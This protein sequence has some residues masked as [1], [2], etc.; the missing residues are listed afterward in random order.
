MNTPG[1]IVHEWIARSGGSEKV[2]E[3]FAR[4]FP[5]API[6]CLWNDTAAYPGRATE[7]WLGRS[8]FRRSKALA[9]PLMPATWR[10]LPRRNVDWMLVSSHLFAHHAKFRGLGVQPQKFVYVH[11]PARYIWNPELDVRGQNRAV[12]ALAPFLRNLDRSRAAEGA[13]FAANS[14]FVKRRINNAWAVDATVIHP[15]VDV[16]RIQSV[17]DWTTQLGP[18]DEKILE[19]L[20]KE[21]LLGASRFVPYKALDDVVRLGAIGRLPVVLA[22]SGPDLPRL[23]TVASELG[24]RVSFVDRPSDQLLFTLYQRAHAYVFPAVEDFGIMPVEAMAAG[25]RVIANRQGGVA[26]S[27]VDGETGVL[28]DFR[29]TEELTSALESLPNAERTSS[30]LRARAFDSSLFEEQIRQWVGGSLG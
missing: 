14:N 17:N 26:E 27:V 23:K 12:R 4:A 1:M 22:G 16:A 10:R 28:V 2:L 25:A 30:T 21:F 13:V 9:L 7:T 5:E 11:T 6:A 24:V 19:E 18:D 8:P 15:P 29:S 3:S 20:P